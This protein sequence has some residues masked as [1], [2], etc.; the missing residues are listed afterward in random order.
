M[1][2]NSVF[3][4][5]FGEPE[6]LPLLESLINANFEAVG[7]PLVHKLQLQPRELSPVH[8]GEKLAIVDIL[9]QDETGRTVNVEVQTT[10][11]PAYFERALFY[12]A[13]LF[14]RQLPQGEDYTKLQPVISLNFLEYEITK[15]GPWLHHFRLPHTSHLGFIFVELPKLLR[16]PGNRSLLKKAAIW[17]KFLEKPEANQPGSPA[18]LVALLDVAK[19]RMEAY[20]MLEPEVYREI[21]ESM[22]RMDYFSVKAEA[23]RME[24]RRIA[25]RLKDRHVPAGEIAEITGLPLAE[26]EKL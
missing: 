1:T 23:S 25:Q 10:R 20:L 17:G 24:Q 21:H 18:D 9:A 22:E 8:S 2:H 26:V 19:K 12:W 11:K 4:H 3:L 5:V 16:S 13:R 7:L 14:A 6:G 15:K